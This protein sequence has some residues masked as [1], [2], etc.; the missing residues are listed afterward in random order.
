M[1]IVSSK[2][3]T[4]TTSAR[5]TKLIK[6]TTTKST[7]DYLKL[8][9]SDLMRLDKSQKYFPYGDDEEELIADAL[10]EYENFSQNENENDDEQEAQD[11]KDTNDEKMYENSQYKDSKSRQ[12]DRLKPDKQ[13]TDTNIKKYNN[14]NY[15]AKNT[16]QKG[17][18]TT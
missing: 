8:L 15:I 12:K 9:E 13:N 11:D 4:A 6:K 1:K 10:D 16:P 2:A 14:E 5:T 7:F 18:D 3:S 17:S